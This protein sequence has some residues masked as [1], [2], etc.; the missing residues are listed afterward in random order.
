M[1]VVSQ[2]GCTRACGRRGDPDVVR[3][4][5]RT[6][7]SQC[8]HDLRIDLADLAI[9]GQLLHDRLAEEFGQI[10][11]VPL[12]TL[13]QEEPDPELADYNGG[14]AD[15]VGSIDHFDDGWMTA[16]E[17]AVCR[18]IEAIA[19]HRHNS[20]SICSIEATAASNCSYS[21]WVHVPAS[22]ARPLVSCPSPRT[23]SARRRRSMTVW[24]KDARERVL[25]FVSASATSGGMLRMVRCFIDWLAPVHSK[26]YHMNARSEE[27]TSE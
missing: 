24:F 7:S 3:G 15:P 12:R 14:H 26:N 1:P 18:R 16:L 5:G 22:L 19:S 8:H 23:P 2:H 6:V 4:D 21:S 13:P 27:H 11:L 10:Y 25:L 17:V 20:S 9:H